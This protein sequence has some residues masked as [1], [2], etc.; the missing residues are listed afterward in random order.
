MSALPPR[1]ASLVLAFA[2]LSRQQTW[3]SAGIAVP[4]RWVLLRDPFARFD[5][6]ALL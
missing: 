6:Q 3:L 5:P 4:I 2:R 1:F